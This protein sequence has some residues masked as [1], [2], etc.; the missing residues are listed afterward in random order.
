MRMLICLSRNYALFHNNSEAASRDFRAFENERSSQSAAQA[1]DKNGVMYFGLLSELAI[2]CWNSKNYDYGDENIERVVIDS[3]TL[4]FPS[5]I[6]VITAKDGRQELWVITVSFQRFMTGTLTPTD[7]NFRIQAAVVDELVRGT[8]CDVAS[9][10]S[11]TVK[12][13]GLN[14]GGDVVFPE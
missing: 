8:K 9:I 5:G 12:E 3:N 13:T 7:T 2:G 1:M 4:Q 14:P 6:K 11:N 10:T